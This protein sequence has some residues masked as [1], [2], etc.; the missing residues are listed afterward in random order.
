MKKWIVL[1]LTALVLIA[2]AV[3]VSAADAPE[4][5]ISSATAKVGD[6]V[7]VT[8]SLKHVTDL[9]NTDL[10]IQYD[11][12]ILR[13]T[14]VEKSTEM[15]ADNEIYMMYTDPQNEEDYANSDG[16]SFYLGLLHLYQFPQSLDSCDVVTLTFEAI[17]AG[18][19][20]LV[21]GAKTFQIAERETAPVLHGG[22]VSVTGE[23]TEAD[24]WNYG[25][26]IDPEN[27]YT[28]ASYT[29]PI[30]QT[31]RASSSAQ[32]A[33]SSHDDAGDADSSVAASEEGL[34]GGS[35][36]LIVAAVVVAVVLVISVVRA[37]RN[38]NI[39]DDDK[40]KK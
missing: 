35:I 7:S 21:L 2:A 30:P 8:L 33:D 11:P 3:P 15:A 17:G 5:S 20:Q 28:D 36:L 1:L 27:L 40:K 9:T 16:H 6:T 4:V 29:Y 31:S 26:N 12:N 18:E 39:V 24:S 22:L 37:A 14:K 13:L 38:K 25:A 10:N 34:S 23:Q 19:C 32:Q